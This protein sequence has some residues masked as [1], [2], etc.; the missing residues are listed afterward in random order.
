MTSSDDDRWTELIGY[1]FP[2][3]VGTRVLGAALSPLLF[4]HLPILL[5]AMSP[6]LIHLVAVGPLVDPVLYFSVALVVT[7][8]Q[9]IVGYAFGR[10]FGQ[11]ALDWVMD[12]VPVP[13]P[14]VERILAIVRRLS[15]PAIFVLPG[16]VLGVICGVAGVR[17]KLYAIFVFPAQAFWVVAAYVLGEALF[18]YIAVAREFVVD[19]AFELTGL[20]VAIVLL[21]YLYT[22]WR[23][24]RR[25]Q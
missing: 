20:T 13:D 7:T 15:V 23:R 5:V 4:A 2:A 8:L 25:E 19:H 9:A 18:D 16:P 6:F 21:R 22:W 1:A 10:L 11:K 14:I 24:R 17:R 12:R 3:M